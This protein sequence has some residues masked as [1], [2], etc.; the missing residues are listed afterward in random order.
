MT[1]NGLILVGPI[2]YVSDKDH[3]PTILEKYGEFKITIKS[4][5]PYAVWQF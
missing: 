4:N 5:D 3:R 2:K 1:E